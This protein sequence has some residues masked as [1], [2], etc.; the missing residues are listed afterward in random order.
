MCGN[1][2]WNGKEASTTPVL[3]Q[4]RRWTGSTSCTRL[5]Y[6]GSG[7]LMVSASS[8]PLKR[9]SRIRS[10]PAPDDEILL[11]DFGQQLPELVPGHGRLHVYASC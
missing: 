1:M 11:D 7:L 2:R 8:P 5:G 9:M 10:W 3:V 6:A 4:F